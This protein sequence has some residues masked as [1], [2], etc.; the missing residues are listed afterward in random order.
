[1]IAEGSHFIY[2]LLG[3]NK[4]FPQTFYQQSPTRA[5]HLT[6]CLHHERL[7][8]KTKKT[9]SIHTLAQ[10][11]SALATSIRASAPVC[12]RGTSTCGFWPEPQDAAARWGRAGA[13]GGHLLEIC[14]QE[15]SLEEGQTTSTSRDRRPAG[16]GGPARTPCAVKSLHR[17]QEVLDLH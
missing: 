1:M 17:G 4:S 15:P 7:F 9:S 16:G 11:G 5:F 2:S 14:F 8:S 13:G 10:S 3:P 6:I 12:P